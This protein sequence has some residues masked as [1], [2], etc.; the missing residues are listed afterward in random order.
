MLEYTKQ[1]YYNTSNSYFM[2]FQVRWTWP[3]HHRLLFV[4]GKKLSANVQQPV[5]VK[6]YTG[7]ITELQHFALTL[8]FVAVMI[9]Y[10]LEH[11][12]WRWLTVLIVLPVLTPSLLVWVIMQ[13]LAVEQTFKLDAHLQWAKVLAVQKEIHQTQSLLHCLWQTA[14][15]Y[16][17]VY[18]V[19]FQSVSCV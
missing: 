15:V 10:N 13:V 3:A 16:I 18:K 9:W 8:R 2:Q 19:K 14:Q 4:M 7:G 11:C 12:V 6:Q 1:D 17:C 5:V